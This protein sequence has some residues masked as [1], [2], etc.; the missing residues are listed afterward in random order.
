MPALVRRLLDG[1]DAA[2][3][4]PLSTTTLRIVTAAAPHLSGRQARLLTEAIDLGG[5]VRIDYVNAQGRPSQRVIEEPVLDGNLVIAWCRLRE[6]ERMFN[7]SRIVAVSPSTALDD[8][9][10]Y[11]GDHSQLFLAT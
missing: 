11:G 10:P 6:D 5:E 9:G 8:S 2:P 4:R 1:P 3:V 7:L